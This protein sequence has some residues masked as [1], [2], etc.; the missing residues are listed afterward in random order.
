MQ[1]GYL[2]NLFGRVKEDSYLSNLFKKEN[3]EIV[4]HAAAYKHVPIVESNPVFGLFNNIVSTRV[5]A[6]VAKECNLSHF[7]L[8]S[9]DKAVR[10]TNLMGCSK[11]VSELIT[12]SYSKLDSHTKYLWSVLVT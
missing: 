10:P 2:S 3:V 5:V 6:K 11:R 12:Q 1:K 8:I 9:S 4:F 7:V